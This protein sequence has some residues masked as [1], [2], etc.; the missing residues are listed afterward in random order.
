MGRIPFLFEVVY[1]ALDLDLTLTLLLVLAEPDTA[2]LDG[3]EKTG[4]TL[5]ERDPEQERSPD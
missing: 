5:A 4:Y 1:L 2:S 3:M